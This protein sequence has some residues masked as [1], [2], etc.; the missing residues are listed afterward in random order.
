MKTTTVNKILHAHS[1]T[2]IAYALP[3]ENLQNKIG[4]ETRPPT[5]G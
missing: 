4:N 5:S 1:L 2:R 3:V